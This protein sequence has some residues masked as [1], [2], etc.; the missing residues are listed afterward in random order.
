[1]STT[2]FPE[3]PGANSSPD[4]R[5]VDTRIVV[6]T[7]TLVSLVITVLLTMASLWVVTSLTGVI[8]LIVLSLLMAVVLSDLAG[9]LERRGVGHGIAALISIVA[10]LLVVGFV[11]AITIP[12][13]VTELDEF[14]SN[15]PRIGERLRTRLAG[16]PGLYQAL[17]SKIEDLRRDPTGIM[18]G[19][20]HFGWGL[21]T[22]VFAGILMLTLTLYFLIDGARTRASVLRH[23]PRKY[24]ERVAATMTGAAQVIRAYFIGRSIISA[25]YAVFTFVLLMVLH[26]PYAIVFAALGFFFSAIPNIGSLLATVVPSLVALAD[27]GITTAIVVAAAL[28]AY[29]QL[30]NNYIQPRILSDRLNVSPIATMIGV[31]AGGKL[32]GVVGV[33][34]AVPV[35]GMLPVIDRV[36]LHHN[37]NIVM[38]SDSTSKAKQRDRA[39]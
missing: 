30:E 10:V 4:P 25:I 18:T 17:A 28:L 16:N 3:D 29:Q 13:L 24:R 36:W 21:A 39:A 34:L 33:I 32:L 15:L 7:S 8:L 5:P 11:L 22:N 35:V 37:N 9:W 20:F 14:F 31:L 23:T 1:M 19:A 6:P 26:V 12:P 2:R 38:D 27:R